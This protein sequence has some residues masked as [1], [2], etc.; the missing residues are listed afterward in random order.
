MEHIYFFVIMI[1]LSIL[2]HKIDKILNEVKRKDFGKDKIKF[3]VRTK[4]EIKNDRCKS[5]DY[6]L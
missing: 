4:E 5:Q 2:N 3:T 6:L 1:A